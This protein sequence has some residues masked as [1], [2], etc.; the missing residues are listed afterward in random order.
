MR[1][2]PDVALT[3]DNI[4]VVYNNGQSG[5]FGGTSC[6]APLWAAFTALVNQQAAANGHATVGF[7]NPAIYSIGNSS[8]Y[9]SNFHDVT[10][11]NNTNS[12]S[13]TK[14]FAAPGDDLCTGWG[15]PKGQSLIDA[16]TGLAADLALT[17]SASPNPATASLP[18]TYTLTITNNGPATA[19][20]VTVT[21]ALP[22]SVTFSSVSA[23]QGTCTSIAWCCHVQ[24]RRPHQ[25]RCRHRHH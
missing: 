18:L 4:Y 3:A 5:G 20:G 11:G 16:L 13:P 10:T 23:S 15:T 25:Q 9:T 12:A 24:S 2:I 14:F 7:I 21:D 6:A 22:A 1:N 17:E 19:I 8:S